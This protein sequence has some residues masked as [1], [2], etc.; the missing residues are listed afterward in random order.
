MKESNPMTTEEARTV[1][2][3]TRP[4]GYMESIHA[5]T[6]ALAGAIQFSM[7]A[8]I[9]GASRP[10]V[11]REAWRTIHEAQPLL[12]ATLRG[13]ELVFSAAFEDVPVVFERRE[14]VDWVAALTEELETPLPSAK[15]LWRATLLATAEPADRN[16]YGPAAGKPTSYLLLTFHHAIVDGAAGVSL[17]RQFVDTYNAL[18]SGGAP[19]SRAPHAVLEPVESYLPLT[20]RVAA[21]AAPPADASL[22]RVEE[23]VPPEMRRQLLIHRPFDRARLESMLGA[24]RSHGAKLTGLLA[25]AMMLSLESMMS[26]LGQLDEGTRPLVMRV[27]RNARPLCAHAFSETDLGDYITMQPVAYAPRRRAPEDGVSADEI[28]ALAV[29]C[30]R[31]YLA[32]P[33]VVRE[34]TRAHVDPVIAFVSNRESPTFR[35]GPILSN[36]GEVDL[37]TRE[38]DLRLRSVD[39]AI[40]NAPLNSCAALGVFTY[41]GEMSCLFNFNTPLIRRPTAERFVEEFTSFLGV[42]LAR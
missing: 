13:E 34:D 3:R 1:P 31:Q 38:G 7:I 39:A 30:T 32:D 10:E 27:P 6:H 16:A 21:P 20:L 23:L 9:D 22:W 41:G 35:H 14:S 37:R 11:A 18:A 40:R 12:G 4:L 24:C 33:L 5:R 19:P 28:W 25:A 2:V 15:A 36:L 8:R 17:V 42:S 29:D 26:R